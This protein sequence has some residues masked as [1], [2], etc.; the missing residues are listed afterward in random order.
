MFIFQ[1]N[2]NI[3]SSA[4]LYENPVQSTLLLS[5]RS[6]AICED[7]PVFPFL[8]DCG[9]L[10][11]TCWFRNVRHANVMLKSDFHK[12]TCNRNYSHE[13]WRVA[14]AFSL[15]LTYTHGREGVSLAS[16]SCLWATGGKQWLIHYPALPCPDLQGR[17]FLAQCSS[18]TP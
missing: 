11:F 18:P 15:S 8:S 2:Y 10:S 5:G 17:C 1:L 12:D 3:P 13:Q 16:G 4:W 9:I 6:G 14:L 7:Q